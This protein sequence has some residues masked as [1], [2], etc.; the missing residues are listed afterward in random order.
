MNQLLRLDPLCRS[1][2]KQ[3][4]REETFKNWADQGR[5]NRE[6]EDYWGYFNRDETLEKVGKL[7]KRKPVAKGTKL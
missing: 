2:T 6:S 3:H 7:L 1:L 5:L 4:F